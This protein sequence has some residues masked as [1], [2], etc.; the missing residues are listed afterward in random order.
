MTARLRRCP[1]CRLAGRDGRD[2]N[3]LDFPFLP[4]G[5]R[6]VVRCCVCDCRGPAAD[7]EAE[8]IAAWNALSRAAKRG[9]RARRT[10]GDA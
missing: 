5:P 8:A 7:T 1:A 4:H 3:A 10:D 6:H 2:V 9:M